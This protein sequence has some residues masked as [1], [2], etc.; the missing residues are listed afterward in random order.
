[1]KSTTL[2]VSIAAL[3]FAVSL[4][5]QT[6]GQ[7]SVELNH[8]YVTLQ[9]GTID[10]IAKSA[11]ISEQF[12]MFEQETIKTV[13]ESW[14]GTYLMG[15]RAYL[16][17]FAPGGSEGLTDGS[18]GI[19]FS[20]SRLGS[21]GAIKRKL[22]SLPGE[23]TLSDLSRKVEGKDNIPWFDSIR[24]QSLD[25]V[26]FSTWLMDFRSDYIKFRNIELTKDGLF[27]R[28][29]YNASRY[30]T[31]EEKK[32]FESRLFNDLSE[33]HLELDASESVSFDKFVTA[34]GYSV[35]EDRGKKAYHEGTFTFFVSTLPNPTYRIRK[36]VCTLKRA[37][38][39]RTE[40]RFGP[41]ARLTVEG[42]TAIWIFGKD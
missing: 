9:K 14:T 15:W 28:H 19:G 33:V 5:A 17:L 21:G 8:V 6:P 36:V 16:E 32:A 20:A 11:F 12:S 31:S 7:P 10:S 1:M 25:K 26:A 42:H 35:S 38:E 27:D 4:W 24:L 18:S 2:V 37:V 34:L 41:D 29:G 22:D 13:T 23:K 3:V 30:T 40:Y 39:P